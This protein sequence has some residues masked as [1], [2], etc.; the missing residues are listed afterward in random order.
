[1]PEFIC[2]VCGYPL[3]R[4]D[5]AL[6][7]ENGHSYDIARQ[8]YVNLLMSNASSSKRHGDNRTM[9]RARQHFLGRGYYDALAGRIEDLAVKYSLHNVSLLDAGCGECWY[10]AR[11]KKAL[12]NAGK[13]V[14]AAGID[15]S[16]SALMAA[17]SRGGDIKTAVASVFSLPI[18]D[19]SCN[20]VL[21]VFAPCAEKEFARVLKKGGILIRAIP[22]EKHLL[23][24]KKAVYDAPYENPPVSPELCGF[25]I[26]EI[27]DIKSSIT[28]SPHED[29]EAL[30]MMTP[31]YYKTSAADQAKL[32]TLNSLET[33][34]EFE[35]IVYKKP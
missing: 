16:K 32:K 25:D 4:R 7:C 33:L 24:L 10:T 5:K 31:Y 21:N 34:I 14:H 27:C 22:L 19:D 17:H 26:A 29:I 20:I 3:H 12:E 30:F 2:P 35:V 1:M 28:V 6:K 11:V 9:V 23:G 8:G 18:G 15:I 13:K